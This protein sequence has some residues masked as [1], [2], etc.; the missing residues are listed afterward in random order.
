MHSKMT[1]DKGHFLNPRAFAV[2]IVVVGRLR[3]GCNLENRKVRAGNMLQHQHQ[4]AADPV[5]GQV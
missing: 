3:N 4:H 5:A 2:S 1:G